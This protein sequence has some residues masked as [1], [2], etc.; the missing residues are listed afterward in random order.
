MVDGDERDGQNKSPI[1]VSI[2]RMAQLNWANTLCLWRN[3]LVKM[4]YFAANILFF[5]LGWDVPSFTLLSSHMIVTP[6][7]PFYGQPQMVCFVEQ[8]AGSLE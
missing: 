5:R 4:Q 1:L 8:S 2:A 3:G 6:P 7:P